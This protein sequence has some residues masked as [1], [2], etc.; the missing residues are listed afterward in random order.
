M[1][2]SNL[3]L[4]N[5]SSIFNKKIVYNFKITNYYFR[6]GQTAVGITD[7]ERYTDNTARVGNPL[8]SQFN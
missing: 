8:R 7:L 3:D 6:V 1:V 2:T 5:Y 4:A